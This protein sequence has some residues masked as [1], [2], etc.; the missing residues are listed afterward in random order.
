M[1]QISP[2][3]ASCGMKCSEM[4]PMTSPSSTATSNDASGWAISWATRR[5]IKASVPGQ[6]SASSRADMAGASARLGALISIM[7]RSCGDKRRRAQRLRAKNRLGAIFAAR[8]RRVEMHRQPEG[9][10][11]DT[12]DH[13]QRAGGQKQVVA[14]AQLDSLA[15]HLEGRLALEQHHPL[16]LRL[17]VIG[18]RYIR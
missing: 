16:V 2:L 13:M 1:R 15:R 10:V 11:G 18:R 12:P 4:T 9:A 8:R 6:P 14:G 7:E 3:N 17:H 5:S